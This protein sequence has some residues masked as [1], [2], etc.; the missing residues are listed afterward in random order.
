MGELTLATRY[1]RRVS[2]ARTAEVLASS[3]FPAGGALLDDDQLDA[4]C[5]AMRSAW[6]SSPTAFDAALAGHRRAGRDYP[7]ELLPDRPA[8]RAI[9]PVKCAGAES[10]AANSPR[11][12]SHRSAEL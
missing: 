11:P 2:V 6:T 9:R 4:L 10:A 3:G 12:V 1:R 5:A 7:A 8:A